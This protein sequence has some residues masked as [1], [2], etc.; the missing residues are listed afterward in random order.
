MLDRLIAY[1]EKRVAFT[2]D[3]NSRYVNWLKSLRPQSHWKPNEE[4]LK[5]LS[6]YCIDN[7]ILTELYEQ[8]KAL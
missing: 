4:Q 1:F 6:K 5:Q 8:L 2:D 3:D 7:R